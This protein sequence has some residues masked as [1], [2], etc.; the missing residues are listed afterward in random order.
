MMLI[1]HNVGE[2]CFQTESNKAR[3]SWLLEDIVLQLMY[4]KVN[5]AIS[6]L[7]ELIR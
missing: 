2:L 6:S 3:I 1:C 4:T 7:D 5:S